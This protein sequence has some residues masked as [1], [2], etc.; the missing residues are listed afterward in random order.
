MR[1]PGKYL[2]DLK[3]GDAFGEEALIA[4]GLPKSEFKELI[5]KPL[6]KPVTIAEAISA[7]QQ[8]A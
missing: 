1:S 6:L 3:L 5:Q 2:A 7:I 8:E 4:D